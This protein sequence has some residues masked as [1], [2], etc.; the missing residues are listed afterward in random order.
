MLDAIQ[1]LEVAEPESCDVGEGLGRRCPDV[2]R[3]AVAGFAWNGFKKRPDGL[4][5]LRATRLDT[6]LVNLHRRVLTKGR[7]GALRTE[8]TMTG[9]DLD[10]SAWIRTQLDRVV[11]RV[12]VSWVGKEVDTGSDAL[13]FRTTIAADG[14]VRVRGTA[15]V[16]G[17]AGPFWLSQK[18]SETALFRFTV[19]F[20]LVADRGAVLFQ[21]PEVYLPDRPS[22]EA[23]PQ[24][25]WAANP[26]YA[27]GLGHAPTPALELGGSLFLS[28]VTIDP[29]ASFA[30]TAL[31]P[32]PRTP[33]ALAVTV[34]AGPPRLAA[35]LLPRKRRRNSSAAAAQAAASPAP[36]KPLRPLR[37]TFEVGDGLPWLLNAN[38]AAPAMVFATMCFLTALFQLF[39]LP[40]LCL[41]AA[42]AAPAATRGFLASNPFAAVEWASLLAAPGQVFS[43]ALRTLSL[44]PKA[45]AAAFQALGVVHVVAVPKRAVLKAW[46]TVRGAFRRRPD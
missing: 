23:P 3:M 26:T 27:L 5:K 44:F 7:R 14:R 35:K 21:E 12:L 25:L 2:V 30:V 28:S 6:E 42:A 15:R 13:K 4:A 17:A 29:T 32:S 39:A 24:W 22:F 38:N 31:E 19:S 40:D 37:T 41:R 1:R 46:R 10:G 8:L 11:R 45:C 36:P 9:A 18:P 33:Y 16:V 34:E 20:R 43:A